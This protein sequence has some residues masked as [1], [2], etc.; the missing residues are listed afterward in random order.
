MNK[1]SK[2]WLALSLVVLAVGLAF[3]WWAAAISG[4]EQGLGEDGKISRNAWP[5]R[6]RSAEQAG[7]GE[8]AGSA[9]VAGVAGAE[10]ASGSTKG[11]EAG[12]FSPDGEV[13]AWGRDLGEKLRQGGMSREEARAELQRWQE[14]V[15]EGD[16]GEAAA[17]LVAILESGEDAPTGLGFLV[18][19]EGV[20]DESPSLRTAAL[21]LLAQTDPRQALEASRAL[22]LETDNPDELALALRNVAWLNRDGSENAFLTAQFRRLLDEENW[23][24][25]PSAGFL[26][27]FDVA[28]SVGGEPMWRELGSV[29]QMEGGARHP[30]NQAAFVA[31]DRLMLR[32]PGVLVRLMQSDPN[33]LDWAPDHRASLFS[34]LD[35][36][37]ESQRRALEKFWPTLGGDPDLAFYFASVFPNRN[38]FSGYRLVTTAEGVAG[39]TAQDR[40]TLAQVRAWMN[41]PAL[42]AVHPALRLVEVRLEELLAQ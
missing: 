32:E 2:F 6:E 25:E 19:A 26:E 37:E 14:L 27:A 8:A 7:S 12:K 11:R 18:G 13:I 40:A 24:A 17:A 16:P 20:L 35:V 29:L 4:A 34:R 10:A 30:T 5:E 1:Q 15:H 39:S 3:W 36:R 21:D 42:Q 23:L 38:A 9:G 22:A 31:L 33:W 41:D 28:V